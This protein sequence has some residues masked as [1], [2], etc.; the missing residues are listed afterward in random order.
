MAKAFYEAEWFRRA[1]DLPPTERLKFWDAVS[2]WARNEPVPDPKGPS[3]LLILHALSLLQ[4]DRNHRMAVSRKR[5]EAGRMGAQVWNGMRSSRAAAEA[6]GAPGPANAEEQ[7][8][9]AGHR[10]ASR[11]NRA[12]LSAARRGRDNGE[13]LGIRYQELEEHGKTTV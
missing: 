6:G 2:A 11:R 9:N 13:E 4:A 1:G 10:R 5:S 7:A 8:A 3:R 12:S